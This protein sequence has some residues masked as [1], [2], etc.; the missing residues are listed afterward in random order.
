MT[1]GSSQTGTYT[2]A[3]SGAGSATLGENIELS[4]TVSGS[5]FASAAYALEYD[6]VRLSLKSVSAGEY[7]NQ[8]G[9]VTVVDYGATKAVPYA[10]TIT[11]QA[12]L[13]GV[14]TVALA[15]AAFGTSD[16]SETEDLTEAALS[17]QSLLLDFRLRLAAN[18]RLPC[19]PVTS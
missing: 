4:V 5:A 2:A 18:R 3:L 17:Q 1:E 19:Q 12:I 10:Y 14:A 16:S 11:F 13:D 8:N 7:S 15:E 6:A 9:Q